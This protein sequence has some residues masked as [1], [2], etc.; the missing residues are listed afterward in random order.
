MTLVASHGGVSGPVSSVTSRSGDGR[1]A[2]SGTRH[3]H[4]LSRSCRRHT[5]LKEI[6]GAAFAPR[7]GPAV[8][9][10]YYALLPWPA[11]P[12]N[13]VEE[14][15]ADTES[16]TETVFPTAVRVWSTRRHRPAEARCGL[17]WKT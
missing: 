2:R 5:Q 8:P 15:D 3:G 11:R 14:S 16:D 7:P 12:S 4:R 9:V 17:G 10:P 1:H 13:V 6:A